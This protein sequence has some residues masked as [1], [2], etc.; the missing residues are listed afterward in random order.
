MIRAE[1]NESSLQPGRETKIIDLRS[2][3][4]RDRA[5]QICWN[6][7]CGPSYAIQTEPTNPSLDALEEVVADYIASRWGDEFSV[8]VIGCESLESIRKG[9]LTTFVDALASA[10]YLA[11]VTRLRSGASIKEIE[12]H[13]YKIN[14]FSSGNETKKFEENREHPKLSGSVRFSC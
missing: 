9:Y 13:V 14:F 4:D 2:V 12:P 3:R 1:W 8:H 7:L 5:V 6:A 10:Q 11:L